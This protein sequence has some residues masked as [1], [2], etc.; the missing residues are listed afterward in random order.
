ML[1]I[2]IRNLYPNLELISPIYCS[3]N[4]MCY[5][6]PSQQIGNRTIMKANFR[7]DPKQEYFMGVLLYKLQRK[8][9]NGIDNQPNNS[10]VSIKDMETNIYLLVVWDVRMVQHDF[11]VC[12][13]ECTN[14]SIW[15][16][17]KLFALYSEYK[18]QFLMKHTS[19]TIT[20]LIHDNTVV[21]TRHD[22]TYGSDCKLDIILSEGTGKYVMKEPLK[23]D[24]KRS[25]LLFSMLIVLTYVLSLPIPPSVKLNI[26]NQCLNVDL[27]SPTYITDSWLEC[28]RP[29]NYKVCAGDTMRS[30]F[31]IK[32]NHEL[33]GALIYKLQRQTHASTEIDE[34]TL[35]TAH[36]LVFWEIYK[37]EWLR[38]DVLLVEHDKGFDWNK[39]D[40]EDL[41]HKN[42]DQ[43]RYF[44][45]SDTD[46]WSLDDNIALM[47]TFKAVGEDCILDITISEIER[48]IDTRTPIY[49]WGK[50]CPHLTQ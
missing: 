13:I 46:I 6:P 47:T 5:V 2:T 34:D 30:S 3:N 7:I 26:H 35:N 25:V 24:I 10:I 32:P 37:F 20:W 1:N 43:F 23:I 31:I 50:L 28:H 48:D 11:C 17:D 40:L 15:D 44:T 27:V 8:H 49:S 18:D 4:T 33:Y 39:D 9:T 42:S 12:L 16:K 14:Y 45:N 21:K 22:V 29:P 41:Y 19:N 38:T 36:L